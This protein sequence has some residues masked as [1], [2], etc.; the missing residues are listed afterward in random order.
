MRPSTVRS[1]VP[2]V[3]Y[4]WLYRVEDRHHQNMNRKLVLHWFTFSLNLLPSVRS[5][6]MGKAKLGTLKFQRKY[7]SQNA[8]L[9]ACPST[10]SRRFFSFLSN[11][12]FPSHWCWSRGAVC[13]LLGNSCVRL[14][15][16]YAGKIYRLILIRL[17]S[18]E[19]TQ[20]VKF[21]EL[22]YRNVRSS[23]PNRS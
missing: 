8:G 3:C 16:T 2:L 5:F 13:A 17:S 9:S 23:K 11:F 22:R 1:S 12:S 21:S 10:Y 20:L 15:W 14:C 7:N 19:V 4:G 18:L 6:F